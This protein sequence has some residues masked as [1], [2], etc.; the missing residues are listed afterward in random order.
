[1][2]AKSTKKTVQKTVPLRPGRNGGLL[3]SGNPGNK[4][5]G[6]HKEYA[7]ER[8]ELLAADPTVW[9]VQTARAKSGDLKALAFASELAW[10]KP[11][12]KKELTGELRIVV[13]YDDE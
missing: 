9:D 3:Q 12:E 5:G 7:T 8:A 11:T 1:M 2:T 6:R 4:G 10:G 13:A